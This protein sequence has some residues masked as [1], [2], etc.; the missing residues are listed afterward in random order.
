MGIDNRSP[1]EIAVKNGLVIGK[2]CSILDGVILDPSFP[3]LIEIGDR[4]TLT[5]NV[6]VLVHDA[7]T[8]RELGYTRIS[9]VKI[10]NDVFVGCRSIILP[11]VSIGNR[12]IIGAGSI[13]SHSIPDDCVAVG[14]PCAPICSYDDF[15]KRKKAIMETAPIYE[16]DYLIHRITTEKCQQMRFE[17]SST[18]GFIR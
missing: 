13:V 9:K 1:L 7:S 3:W 12:V 8:K 14:S 2:E 4:V 17:L 16:E 18:E 10:G 15:L 6:Q 11:G 5:P